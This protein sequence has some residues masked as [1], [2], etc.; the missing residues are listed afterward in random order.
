MDIHLIKAGVANCYIIRDKGIIL[1]D[2]GMPGAF[3]K[4]SKGLKTKGIDS[5]DINV[6]I[7]T[8]C[9]WDHIGCAKEIKDFTGAKIIVQQYEKSILEKGEM[10]MPPAITRWGKV[11]A[12]FL[13]SWSKK[14]SIAP[15]EVD[16]VVEKEDLSLGEFGIK[17]D[18]VFTPGHSPGSI[19]VVLDTGDAFVGDMAMNGLPLTLGP[20][21]PIF[22]ED[23]SL[24]KNS[25][26]KLMDKGVDTIHPAHGRPFSVKKLIKKRIFLPVAKHLQ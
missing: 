10:A 20:S 13:N 14:F 24:L 2:G 1:V 23:I 5:K 3:N 26:T 18:I 19:S 22:A 7:I 25:W 12:A 4:F 9:H 11:F 6:I 15:T 21:L 17:G 16:M 8:H